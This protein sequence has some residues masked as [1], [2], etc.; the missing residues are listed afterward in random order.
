VAGPE[1]ASHSVQWQRVIV[2][3]VDGLDYELTLDETR[4]ILRWLRTANPHVPA[5]DPGS[6]AAAVFLE[7]LLEDAVATNPPMNDGEAAGI[8]IA[9]GRM[10]LVEGLT[11]R[12]E[13]LHDALLGRS[14]G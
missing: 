5:T 8:L 2:V 11:G 9:L 12:Q 4:Q 13:A 14:W 7:R 3:E 10:L 6:I 1:I